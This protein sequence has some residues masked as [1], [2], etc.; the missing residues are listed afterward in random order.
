MKDEKHILN[1]PQADYE[2][3]EL[4]LLRDGLNRTYTQRFERMTQLIK[5]GFMLKN[6]KV[7]HK[8]WPT[9]SK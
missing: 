2:K 6:A 8:P 1:E 5:L 9:Q 7:T 4:D 3:A